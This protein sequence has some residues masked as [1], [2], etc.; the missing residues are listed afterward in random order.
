MQQSNRMRLRE[1]HTG[2]PGTHAAA[3]V[4]LCID[5]CNQACAGNQHAP[6]C[7]LC[8]CCV[9]PVRSRAESARR[10]VTPPSRS[11]TRP[12]APPSQ[13]RGTHSLCCP[14]GRRRSRRRAGRVS[15]HGRACCCSSSEGRAARRRG[16]RDRRARVLH[17]QQGARPVCQHLL[18][19]HLF[20]FF[21]TLLTMVLSAGFLSSRTCPM[22]PLKGSCSARRLRCAM[23]PT[24]SKELGTSMPAGSSF[25]GGRGVGCGV[26]AAGSQAYARAQPPPAA[27][28]ALQLQGMLLVVCCHTAAAAVLSHRTLSTC[29]ADRCR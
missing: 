27:A 1:G 19:T 5:A 8:G 29:S 11:A 18:R 16:W 17:A 12:P 22:R 4:W 14:A 2:A 6:P 24:A 13:T 7:L 28:A 15:G 3:C 23:C 10:A 20:F 9:T 21:R 26:S 25:C